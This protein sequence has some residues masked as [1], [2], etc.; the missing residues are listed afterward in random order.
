MMGCSV[1]FGPTVSAVIGGEVG[2]FRVFD[3]WLERDLVGFEVGGDDWSEL[4]LAPIT[5]EWASW[6]LDEEDFLRSGFLKASAWR[7]SQALGI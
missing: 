2:N 1:G 4:V 3:P 6:S 7:L 5:A